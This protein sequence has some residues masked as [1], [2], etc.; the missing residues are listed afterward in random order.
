MIWQNFLRVRIDGTGFRSTRI[1]TW[2]HV[3][4]DWSVFVL[5][6]YTHL[7]PKLLQNEWC[8]L[9]DSECGPP[10]YN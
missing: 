8:S 10:D 7:S 5:Y 2:Q 1:L 9:E 6:T 3:I 4:H